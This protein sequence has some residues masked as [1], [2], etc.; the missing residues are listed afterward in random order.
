MV[1][2]AT[3]QRQGWQRD[4]N[5]GTDDALIRRGAQHRDRVNGVRA[6][7]CVMSSSRNYAA[8]GDWERVSV[9]IGPGVCVRVRLRRFF[10]GGERD[11]WARRS[12]DWR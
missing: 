3:T 1:S 7:D 12:F 6:L 8:G 5:D 11:G 9:T 2:V 10:G 4:G